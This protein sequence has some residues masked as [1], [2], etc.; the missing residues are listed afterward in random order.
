[1]QYNIYRGD[2]RHHY[3]GYN[4]FFTR[5]VRTVYLSVSGKLLH[6]EEKRKGTRGGMQDQ[7]K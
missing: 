4:G 2:F 7:Q 3:R 5:S 1:M 6:R